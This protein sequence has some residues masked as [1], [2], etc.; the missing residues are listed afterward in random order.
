[1]LGRRPL[2]R[3]TCL[4]ILEST[5]QIRIRV[6]KIRND[7]ARYRDAGHFGHASAETSQ[8]PEH[9]LAAMNYLALKIAIL[10]LS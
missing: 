7:V 4:P 8:I 1:M 6:G 5:Q 3:F 9:A 2:V 10:S